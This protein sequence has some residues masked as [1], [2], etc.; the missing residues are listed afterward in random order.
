MSTGSWCYVTYSYTCEYMKIQSFMGK[1][2]WNDY[3]R[4]LWYATKKY[5]TYSSNA[6]LLLTS[7]NQLDD[8]DTQAIDVCLMWRYP[9]EHELGGAISSASLTLALRHMRKNSKS[10]LCSKLLVILTF[11]TFIEIED[12]MNLDTDM[13]RFIEDA[14][15][16][17]K[18]KDT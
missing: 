12:I 6:R 1:R 17:E 4:N 18:W 10:S 3:K 5:I 16:L 8:Y 13:S 9:I 15:N 7:S 2:C 11:T 14:K